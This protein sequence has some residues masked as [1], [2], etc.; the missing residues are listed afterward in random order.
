MSVG[1]AVEE[2]DNVASMASR[3][4]GRGQTFRRRRRGLVEIADGRRRRLR[5]R[6]EALEAR[7]GEGRGQQVRVG[8]G[9]GR[10]FQIASRPARV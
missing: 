5:A 6:L 2:G 4:A 8:G 7:R 9:V 10:V 1:I 3:D